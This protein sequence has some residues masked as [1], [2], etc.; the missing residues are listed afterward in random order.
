MRKNIALIV[1]L[2]LFGFCICNGSE[3]LAQRY[4]DRPIQIVVP[5]GAGGPADLISRLVGDQLA[6]ELKVPVA[7]LNKVGAG[8]AIGTSFVAQARKDGYTLMMTTHASFLTA[9]LQPKDVSYDMER[10]FEPIGKVTDLATTLIVRGDA[11]WK[12]VTE[13]FDHIKKNPKKLSCGVAPIGTMPY[14]VWATMNSLGFETNAVIT[15]TTP[16]D[17]ALLKG[18]HIDIMIESVHSCA[19]YFRDKSFRGLAVTTLQRVKEFP[20][21]PTFPESGYPEIGYFPQFAG[22]FAPAAT[23]QPILQTLSSALQKAMKDPLLA[24]KLDKMSYSADYQGPAE[25]KQMI[26]SFI[27]KIRNIAEKAGIIK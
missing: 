1:L 18:R 21:I 15:A 6:K 20:E 26:H 3:V 11:P 2:S 17:I 4:P 12:T 9:I 13:L 7:I 5:F 25:F 24:D 14:F 23:P 22:L 19:P 10:D 16:E 27:P 8:G